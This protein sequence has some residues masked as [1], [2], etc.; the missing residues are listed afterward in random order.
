MAVARVTL[1]NELTFAEAA[2]APA[3]TAGSDGPDASG[4]ACVRVGEGLS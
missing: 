4:D 2:A 3:H 1:E